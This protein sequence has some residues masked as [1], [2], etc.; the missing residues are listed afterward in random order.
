MKV[1]WTQLAERRAIEAAQFVAADKPS[2]ARDWYTKLVEHVASLSRFPRRGRVVPELGQ[3]DVREIFH[4]PYRII[5][6][7][8]ETRIEIVTVWH[9]RRALDREALGR[10]EPRY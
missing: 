5:Y 8:G 4:L 1:V 7:I 3:P 2:A 6:R 10:E 9:E